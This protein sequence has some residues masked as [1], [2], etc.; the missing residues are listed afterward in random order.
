MKPQTIGIPL[1][2]EFSPL[3]ELP[4]P[5]AAI[6]PARR[7]LTSLDFALYGTVVL[8]WG[9]SWG[10]MR[11]QVAVVAPEI[12]GLWRFAIAAP[13]MLLIGALR[14]ERLGY[15]LEDHGRFVM[16]GATMYCVNFVVVLLTR[17]NSSPR[18]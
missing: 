15:G 18:G 14:G 13:A 3:S 16:F 5:V 6:K 7:G 4:T 12:S 9:F 17:R 10:A 1:F 8:L 2:A 11:Y